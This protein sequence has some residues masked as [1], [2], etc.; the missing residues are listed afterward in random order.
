M[1]SPVDTVAKS[2]DSGGKGIKGALTKQMGPLPLW[3]WIA[4][5]GGGLFIAY[6]LNSRNGGSS[7]SGSSTTPETQTDEFGNPILAGGVGAGGMPAGYV[8]N[9]QPPSTTIVQP[10]DNQQWFTQY[11]LPAA[12]GLGY[13]PVSATTALQLFI[14]GG[15][16]TEDQTTLVTRVISSLTARGINMPDPPGGDVATSPK[17]PGGQGSKVVGAPIIALPPT[18]NGK[19]VKFSWTPVTGAVAYNI[20][21]R[22]EGAPGKHNWTN[23]AQIGNQV[24]GN[25]FTFTAA[26]GL[27]PVN[28]RTYQIAIRGVDENGA[29]GPSTT[30]SPITVVKV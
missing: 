8:D 9:S 27:A 6:Y 23:W 26:Q 7:S 5:I 22:Y 3:V 16:L 19:S 15:T 20:S 11:A 14:N 13:N 29:V 28:N 18:N 17:G 1:T 25:S 12:I 4:I 10:T 21:T 24:T 30:N 2:S